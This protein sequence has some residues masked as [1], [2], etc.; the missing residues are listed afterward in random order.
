MET[1][2]KIAVLALLLVL[3]F[4]I[5]IA[6]LFIVRSTG[7]DQG[8]QIPSQATLA[9]PSYQGPKRLKWSTGVWLPNAVGFVFLCLSIYQLDSISKLFIKGILA[10]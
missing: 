2:D 3:Y 5:L 4:A 7:W 10:E 1:S 8:I 9:R 6:I